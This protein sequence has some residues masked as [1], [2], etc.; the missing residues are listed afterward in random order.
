[1]IKVKI[2]HQKTNKL[3]A[4]EDTV[5]EITGHAMTAPYGHDIVCAAVSVLY[6]QLAN[7]LTG[8][9]VDDSDGKAVVSADTIDA[10]NQRL[11]KA[12]TGTIEQLSVQYP[13]NVTLTCG[14]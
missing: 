12:F 11:F 5:V 2:S 7:Y 8:A 4:F 1:M 3:S 14:D 10:G 6:A 9:T 13:K